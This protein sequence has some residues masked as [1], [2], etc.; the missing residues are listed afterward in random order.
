MKFKQQLVI[1]GLVV[2]ANAIGGSIDYLSQQDAEYLA[3]PAM[4]GKIGV[5]GA[6]YNPAGAVWLEDGTYIQV[7]N[8]TH[9]KEY[10]M[11]HGDSKFK[12]DKAS[13]VVP[14]VQIVRK[15]GDTAFFFHAGA[16]AGGGSVAYSG[17]IA[18]F[19]EI[20]S[21]IDGKL[22]LSLEA[23]F[24]NGSTIHGKSYYV[25]L[26]GG[27]A[28][29]FTDTWSGAIGIRLID[30]ERKF[31]GEGNF[32]IKIDKT[33]ITLL[34]PKFD[35]DSERTAFG[36][37]GIFGLN[38]HPNDR[39]NLGMRYET[40]TIL[41]FDN[42]E[43]KLK[44]GFNSSAGPLGDFFYNYIKK[45]PAIKQWMSEGSGKRNLP[46][47]AAIGASYKATE[48]LTLLASGNYYF[49]KET[50]D[51]LGNFD[52]Y[53]NGYEVA[54]G[55]DYQLDEKWTLMAGYQYTDTGANEKTYTDTDYVLD[56]NMYSTGVKYKYSEQLELMAT[57]SYV[58]YKNDKNLKNIKYSKH[59][60]A[61]GLGMIY[62]F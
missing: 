46:A 19:P 5:S 55:L 20:A 14:S 36:V 10:S 27:V 23:S 18:T 24:R 6:Y 48:K 17:G 41:D 47:M 52:H 30:A 60:D 43:N 11:Q 37:A 51:E 8:Q 1:L 28:R 34:S 39:F 4:V 26:Q 50:S 7:N 16:I 2:S 57:Y 35:I 21:T 22:P 59:V 58:D 33:N 61:F 62:K 54:V 53:D 12:S 15:K 9:L 29:K 32:D 44:S 3:H 13:P 38:Y 45:D 56:A 40:E 49:I 42:K 25:A 31:K